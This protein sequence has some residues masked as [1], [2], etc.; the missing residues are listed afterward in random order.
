MANNPRVPSP[1]RVP[2]PALLLPPSLPAPPKATP[3]RTILPLLPLN[4]V[5]TPA[6]HLLPPFSLEGVEQPEG[7]EQAL[8]GMVAWL[9]VVVVVV[10]N[11]LSRSRSPPPPPPLGH[12]SHVP[13]TFIL[14]PLSPPPLL[15]FFWDPLTLFFLLLPTHHDLASKDHMFNA[16]D[17]LSMTLVSFRFLGELLKSK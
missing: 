2:P 13:P 6:T 11:Y 9:S 15:P 7:Q 17:M 12:L 8:S 5:G 3:K 1:P 10:L 4:F 16:L 14:A